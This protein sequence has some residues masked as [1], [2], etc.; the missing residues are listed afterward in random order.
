MTYILA[1]LAAFLMAGCQVDTRMDEVVEAPRSEPMIKATPSVA[2]SESS[3]NDGDILSGR[4]AR[5]GWTWNSTKGRIAFAGMVR[6]AGGMTEFCGVKYV[7]GRD[8]K[9]LNRSVMA[10][11]KFFV[12]GQLVSKG[13]NHFAD[14]KSLDALEKTPV[15][16]KSTSKPWNPDYATADWRFEHS[17]TTSF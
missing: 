17:G 14:A 15:N 9:D 13:T 10:Q 4:V 11:F 8:P 12:D 7:S 5:G 1:T 16:C 2:R 3:V 6:N